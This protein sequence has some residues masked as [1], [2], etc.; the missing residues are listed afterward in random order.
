MGKWLQQHGLNGIDSQQRYRA[1]LV[2][3]NLPAIEGW[4]DGLDEAKRRSLNHP[5]AVWAGWRRTTSNPAL[6]ALA[7]TVFS[8]TSGSSIPA[9]AAFTSP[10]AAVR[11]T[12]TALSSAGR[13]SDYFDPAGRDWMTNASTA[14]QS[15][16]GF[17]FDAACTDC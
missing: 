6:S 1:L 12:M 4:R 11:L 3:E 9:Y 5:G 13:E 14:R 17:R 7:V 8:T 16:P 15:E 2:Q 10:V